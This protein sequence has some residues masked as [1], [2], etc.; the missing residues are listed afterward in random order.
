MRI[1]IATDSWFPDVRGGSARV[2]AE[3]ARRLS[4]RGHEATALAPARQSTPVV[5]T[6]EGFTVLRRLPRSALPNTLSDTLSAWRW[7]RRLNGAFDVLLGHQPTVSTGLGVARGDVPLVLVYHASAV[8][9]NLLRAEGL[10]LGPSQVSSRAQA[11]FLASLENVG[12]RRARRVLVLSK[13]SRSLVIRDHPEVAERIIVVSGG[14]DV[15]KFSP[16]PGRG[17]ARATLGVREDETL[18][19][20]M[21]R[22]EPQLGLETVLHAF[23]RLAPV[24]K[25]RFVVVGEGSL[26]PRLLTLAAELGLSGQVQVVR[27]HSE[28][29][30]G[31]WYRAADLFVL[32]PAQHEGFGLAT[33][34]ALASGTPAVA[35]SVGASPEILAPLDPRFLA[36]SADPGDLASAMAGVLELAGPELRQRCRE[37]ATSRFAWDRVIQAWESALLDAVRRGD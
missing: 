9:E 36:R 7:A 28:E 3:T 15:E 2:A 33:I 18:L 10:P 32:P 21:R 20:S 27:S 6:A 14:V 37:Y 1:L 13:Y 25:T 24:K 11:A 26:A 29:E 35:A 19:V 34:E 31:R 12:M 5:D 4:A 30:L 17:I 22:L 16:A 23:H 8:R